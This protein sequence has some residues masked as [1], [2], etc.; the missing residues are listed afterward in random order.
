MST[1]DPLKTFTITVEGTYELTVLEIW[2]DGDEPE[3]PT[4]ADVAEVMERCGTKH[5]V[6]HDWMLDSAN[7]VRVYGEHGDEAKVWA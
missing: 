6:L 4:A 7:E 1:P 2:P 5:S 3:H